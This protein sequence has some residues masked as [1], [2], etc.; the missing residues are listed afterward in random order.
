M[1]LWTGIGKIVESNSY[2]NQKETTSLEKVRWIQDWKTSYRLSCELDWYTQY[3]P[4]RKGPLGNNTRSCGKDWSFYASRLSIGIECSVIHYQIG[5]SFL[6]NESRKRKMFREYNLVALFCMYLFQADIL[7]PLFRI[8]KI[9]ESMQ[10]QL[11]LDCF[12]LI[13][14]KMVGAQKQNRSAI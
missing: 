11:T 9:Q 10:E 1:K 4:W 12:E 3:M 6:Y 13:G 2:K 5:D 7:H 14:R 8:W